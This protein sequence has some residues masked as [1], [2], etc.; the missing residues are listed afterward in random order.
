MKI[1]NTVFPKLAQVIAALLISLIFVEL[2]IWQLHRAQDVQI[3]NKTLPDKP[4]IALA[5]VAGAG[6][7]LPPFAANRIVKFRGRYVK[8]YSAPNQIIRSEG[9]NKKISLEVRLLK[10]TSGG[11]ILVVRGAEGLKPQSIVDEVV[12]TGRLYPRQSADSV[13]PNSASA[14][15]LARIDPALVAGQTQLSLFDGYVIA[16]TEK[17]IYGQGI[18]Q[19]RIPSPQLKSKSTGYYWQ[20]ITYV[21]IWWLLAA[22]VLMV[23]F[24]DRMKERGV[25]SAI[26]RASRINEDK[27]GI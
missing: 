5:K 19:D 10:L 4:V 16:R 20:H 22:L 15:L 1:T 24:Y 17:T 9:V 26:L 8:T 7:N 3:A 2:G 11:A 18:I 14:N 25:K 27:V 12:I 6:I 21:F 23:P 13:V